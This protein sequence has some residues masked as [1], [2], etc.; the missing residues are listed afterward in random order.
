MVLKVKSVKPPPTVIT[1]APPPKKTAKPQQPITITRK[2]EEEDITNMPVSQLWD[3][4][5]ASMNSIHTAALTGRQLRRH[6]AAHLVHLGAQAL[7]PPAVPSKILAG[8]RQK[9]ERRRLSALAAQHSEGKAG[10]ACHS[11]MFDKVHVV[12]QSVY[13]ARPMEVKKEKLRLEK[14]K[15]YRNK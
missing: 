7:P 13:G 9:R 4:M 11:S 10:S 6:Q 8:M 12:N 1:Y 2:N 15:K 5:K 14:W 3:R